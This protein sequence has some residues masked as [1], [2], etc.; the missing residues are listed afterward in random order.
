MTWYE[1]RNRMESTLAQTRDRPPAMYPT[2]PTY[3]GA[4]KYPVKQGLCGR[5][6]LAEK[7][8]VHAPGI[9]P[10]GYM[11]YMGYIPAGR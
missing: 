6:T 4:T 3:P 1:L 11:G 2:C 10:R 9:G 7:T 8:R 5:G